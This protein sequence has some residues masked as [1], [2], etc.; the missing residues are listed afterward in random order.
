MKKYLWVNWNNLEYETMPYRNSFKNVAGLFEFP[1]DRFNLL[2]QRLEL[3]TVNI[4]KDPVYNLTNL[5]NDWEDR[6]YAILDN[7]A[8]RVYA[9]AQ[10][11]TIVITWSGG[12]DSACVLVALQKHPRYKEFL[13]A[14]KI[15][16]AL[17]STSIDEYPEQF[18]RDILPSMPIIALDYVRLMN[19]PGIMLVTGDM[20]DHV[21]GSTDVLRFTTGS[22]EDLDLMQPWQNIF[23]AIAKI[24]GSEL[25]QDL[26]LTIAKKAPF[27]I[28][29]INQLQW[30]W[31]N[32]LDH[33]DDLLRPWYWSTVKDLTEIASQNK[34]FRFFYDSELMTF[35]FEYMSTNPVYHSYIDNKLWP[36]KY[37]VNANKDYNYMNKQKIFSQRMSLRHTFKTQLYSIDN[38]L[39]F[40]T[41]KDAVYG[42][43]SI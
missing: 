29:S 42:T 38:T 32:A 11:K 28:Q 40:V 18:F 22:H 2:E 35:S 6:Y 20:G 34:I 12:I 26:V 9:T 14:G 33:Q 23:P 19:D 1:V 5:T 41:G 21:I 31:A 25:Y 7:I 4:V 36:K 3:P 30:W 10:D 39:G 15:K 17:T 27:E 8:G 16:V 13:E 43:A 37:I 24:N